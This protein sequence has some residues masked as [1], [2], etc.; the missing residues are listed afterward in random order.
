MGKNFSSTCHTDEDIGFTFSMSMSGAGTYNAFA[1]PAHG[2]RIIL[3]EKDRVETFLFNSAISHC[4]ESV[5]RRPGA[6]SFLF[7]L[8]TSQLVTRLVFGKILSQEPILP[9]LQGMHQDR[10]EREETSCCGEGS[11]GREEKRRQINQ[12][13]Q[14]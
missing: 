6:D 5:D 14:P 11:M 9:L 8:Y 12:K 3:E 10:K 13:G 7:S 4:A 1:F 2:T